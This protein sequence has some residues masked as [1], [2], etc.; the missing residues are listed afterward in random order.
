MNLNTFFDQYLRTVQIPTLEY[1]FED[2]KFAYR[3]INAVPGFDMPIKVKLD[4]NEQWINPTTNWK[5]EYTEE[6]KKELIIDSNFY[7]ASFRNMKNK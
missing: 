7:V 5:H 1:F 3:W 4:N 2:N 6:T